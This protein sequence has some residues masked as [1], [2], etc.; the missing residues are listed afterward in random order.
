MSAVEWANS[1]TPLCLGEAAV[2]VLVVID[3]SGSMAGQRITDAKAAAKGFVDSMSLATDQAGVA[4][5]SDTGTLD[6]QLSHNAASIKSSID[7]IVTGGG[8]NIGGGITA[9]QNELTS[10]RHQSGSLPIIVLLTDGANTVGDPIAAANA[11]KAGGTRIIAIGLGEAN[12]P[13]M[14]SVVS[15]PNDYYY[16]PSSADLSGLYTSIA[17]ELCRDPNQN[18]TV[19]AGPDQTITLPA[20]ASLAGTATDDGLPTGAALTTTWSK[21]S[22]A[23]DHGDLQ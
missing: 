17:G 15:S 2:D 19:D 20:T 1:A 4:S 3:R 8:T 22:G 21:V 11:A 10:P 14:L 6:H 7:A 18:P 12:N 9:A 5:F 23:R 13:Q 16:A